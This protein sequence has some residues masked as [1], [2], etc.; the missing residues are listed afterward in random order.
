MKTNEPG[1]KLIARVYAD[2]AA[3]MESLA[4][5]SLTRAERIGLLKQIGYEAA[6]L[7]RW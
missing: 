5:A 6:G 1:R 2:H 4:S 3:D 7:C